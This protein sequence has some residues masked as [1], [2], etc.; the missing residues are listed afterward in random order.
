[1][2]DR[3]QRRRTFVVY[4]ILIVV[5]TMIGLV[6]NGCGKKEPEARE[7]VRP[8]KMMT[9]GLGAEGGTR[10]Y[11]GS[12]RA[13]EEAELGFEVPG[14]IVQIDI[15]EGQ[16]LKAG[17]L[18]ARLD[19]QDF[20]TARERELAQ[21]NAARADL[22][23]S[24]SLYERDAI[25][26]RD[27]EMVRRQAEVTEAN[28][29]Q[30]EKALADTRLYAPYDGR[31]AGRHVESYEN[32]QAKQPVVTYHD[33]S[34]LVIK[35]N[36]PETEYLSIR[37]L[38]T[39]VEMTEALT[40]Q[41]EITAAAGRHIDAWVKELKNTADPITRTYEVTLGFH[42]PN[43][44]AITSGMTATAILALK[45]NLSAVWVPVIAVLQGDDQSSRVW[46]YD[47]AS[48]TVTARTV[49]VGQLTGSQ[50]EILEG[51][52]DGDQIAILGAN[53][54]SEGMKVRPLDQN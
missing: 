20:E 15:R 37:E 9:I 25:S 32:V 21:R 31:V 5:L 34:S 48:S 7:I 3:A 53:N 41:V 30:A 6:L 22:Q 27:L 54:L 18:V 19:P 10:Q 4:F 29:K 42:A 17:D 35:A 33:D 46:V 49:R 1:M 11:P 2:Q 52:Q 45:D 16:A 24:L 47:A 26:L 44:L 36:V 38:G 8:V 51:L 28:L 43:D 50:I 23:R 14:R 39:V 13:S 40:P 12:I